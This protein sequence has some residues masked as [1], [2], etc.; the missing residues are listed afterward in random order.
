MG[1]SVPGFSPEDAMRSL[2]ATEGAFRMLTVAY[3]LFIHTTAVHHYTRP[4]FASALIAFQCMWSG[5]IALALYAQPR[6]RSLLVAA[7]IVVTLGLM[8]STWFIADSTWWDHNQSLPTT[9]WVTN[10][11][12]AAGMQWGVGAGF[13]AGVGLA[14]ASLHIGD[15]LSWMVRS[16]T[17]PILMSAGIAAGVGGNGARRSHAQL[18]AALEMRARAA[19]RER[20]AREVHDGVLQVLALVGREGPA[21]GPEGARLGGLATEQERALRTLIADVDEAPIANTSVA[22][23]RP[24]GRAEQPTDVR[25]ELLALADEGVRVT[26][27]S[28]AVFLDANRAAELLAA[29]RQALANTVHHAG[30]DATAYVLLEDLGDE[31]VVTVRDDG[32]GIVE[33]RIDEAAREGRLGVARS[34]V[35]RIEELGGRAHLVTAPGEGVE[36]EFIV[37]R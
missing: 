7:D 4:N 17:I 19:E 21:L 31:V 5:F 16:P 23:R 25:R 6:W 36:W 13:V 12:L 34:I 32:V 27:G 33:G 11:V 10:A 9:M 29:T 30:E 3:S 24:P 28:A 8:Y 35:G 2:W 20:L 15:D 18:T 26:G 37:P 1:V 14:L 22:G